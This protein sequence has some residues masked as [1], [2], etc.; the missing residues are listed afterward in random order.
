MLSTFAAQSKPAN[1][2]FSGERLLNYMLQ[3]GDGVSPA[4]LLGRSGLEHVDVVV[5]GGVVS[6]MAVLDGEIYC[7]GGGS[8]TKYIGG[9]DSY[10]TIGSIPE[11][12]SGIAGNGSQIAIV[13][14]GV[15]YVYDG[16][17]LDIVAVPALRTVT[18]VAF[19][20]GYFVLTGTTETRDDALTISGLYDG[21]TFDAGDIAFAEGDPDGIVGLLANGGDLWVLGEKT[22]EL[23]YNSGNARFPIEPAG[24]ATGSY[25]CANVHAK[26][27]V[28]DT[29][30]WV[31]PD[32]G[33]MAAQGYQATN[34]A[35]P[36][37]QTAIA[38]DT[39]L[40]M[41]SFVDRGHD[42]VAIHLAASP[43][44]CFDLTTGLW[45]ERSTGADH[46]PWIARSTI[47]YDGAEYMGGND[48]QLYKMSPDC[49]EDGGDVIAAQATA[50]PLDR[51]GKY[52]RVTRLYANIKG[53]V[54]I[55][56]DAK[57][58]LQTSRDGRTWSAAKERVIGGSGVHYKRVTWNGLGAFERFQA[59]LTITDPVPRDIHGVM[60]E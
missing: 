34:I 25:G 58:V 6:H 31:R 46:A 47:R 35:T 30:I 13:G 52:F 43:T 44:P 15:L 1:I 20:D 28:N 60:L 27:V 3:P 32:G 16:E 10:Q 45:Q 39:V 59:R 48:R 22:Y 9:M 18:D 24:D 2:S 54:G 37:I 38:R 51:G 41:S 5:P 40:G 8:L 56:R 21:K 7:C 42:I 14:E 29:P 55:D 17:D 57:A 49:F 26:T 12:I 4:D 53:G 50:A 23:F 11:D 19:M 36:E 33:V